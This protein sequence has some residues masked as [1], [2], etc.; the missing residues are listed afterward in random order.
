LVALD[1]MKGDVRNDIMTPSRILSARFF[2]CVGG[3]NVRLLNYLDSFRQG[4][5]FKLDELEEPRGSRG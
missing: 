1:R 2:N 4:S 3:D 5:P